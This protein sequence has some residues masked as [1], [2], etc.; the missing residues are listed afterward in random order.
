[1]QGVI[2]GHM[3]WIT[4]ASFSSDGK[5]IVS[6]SGDETIRLW[7]AETGELVRPPLEGHQS[8]VWSVAFSPD[9]K[10]IVSGSRD[11]TIRL[12]DAE[13]GEL[14]RPPLEGHQS[15]VSSVAFSP[16]GKRIVSESGDNTIRLSAYNYLTNFQNNRMTDD[17]WFMGQEDDLLFWVPP[18]LH[19][20]GL[21]PV[22]RLAI[23]G[24]ILDVRLLAHGEKWH[25][26]NNVG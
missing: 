8:F 16:D 17:G 6:G 22:T 1:M 23:G 5:R 11:K 20:I 15:F 21:F 9:G 7:D 3:G 18:Y 10:R 13:T 24:S 14:V 26:I 4:C 19:P 12:W 2:F 25:S